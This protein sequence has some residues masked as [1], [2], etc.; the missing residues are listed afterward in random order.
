MYQKFF[1]SNRQ[2]IMRKYFLNE[3]S[4]LGQVRKYKKHEL[5]NINLES[6]VAIVVKGVVTQSVISLKGHEKALY[7]IRPGEI[8]GEMVYFCGGPDSIIARAKVDSEIS[9]INK[10]TLEQ[11][12]RQH[13][14]IYRHFIHSITRKFRIVMLQLT[15]TTFN[16]SIGRIAD[17]LLRLSSC[18]NDDSKKGKILNMVFTHQELAYNIGCS[19]ITVTKCLNEFEKRNIIGYE[20]KKIIINKPEELE[21]YIDII[22]E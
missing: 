14:D 13:P 7:L 8:F 6:Y 2:S 21:K 11:E 20:N 12:L 17:T 10:D 4:K 9:I 16:D 18:E 15:N 3:A 22:E 5:I 19:R 1:D